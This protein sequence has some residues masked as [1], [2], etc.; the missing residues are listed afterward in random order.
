M[1]WINFSTLRKTSKMWRN[2]FLKIGNIHRIELIYC[3][4]FVNKNLNENLKLSIV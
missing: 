4:I 1:L 2:F 3:A